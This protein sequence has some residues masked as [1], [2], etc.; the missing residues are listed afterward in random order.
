MNIGAFAQ[1]TGLSV[2]ALRLYDEQGLLVPASVDPWSRYRRYAASQ[3]TSAVRLKALREAGVPLAEAARALGGPAEAEESLARHRVR[4]AAERASQDAAL[5]VL[6]E[7]VGHGAQEWD[8]QERWA[9]AQP[10]V[11]VVMPVD[12]A[13]DEEQ[14]TE[15]ANGAF[16]ALWR[17]LAAE[18][19]AP[20]GPFWSS[21]RVD[22]DDEEAVEAL[23]CYP[24]A[25]PL[26]QDWGLDGYEVVTGQVPAGPELALRWRYDQPSGHV[27]GT[28]HPAMIALLVEAERRGAD[29]DW[30]SLRQVGAIEDG[31]VVGMDVTASLTAGV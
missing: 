14:A 9:Q 2:K 19:V 15:R 13:D 31:Q 1:L 3:L 29:L 11:G 30:L 16:A 7:L 8:V 10:W 23:C 22:A 4:V 20:T 21:F 26:P 5:G 25:R 28:Q 17:A 12:P 24:V 6:D 27:D 18:G